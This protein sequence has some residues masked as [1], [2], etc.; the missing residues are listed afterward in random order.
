MSDD[1]DQPVMKGTPIT[2]S[3]G[4]LIRVGWRAEGYSV[5]ASTE[6]AYFIYTMLLLAVAILLGIVVAYSVDVLYFTFIGPQVA[7]VV[8]EIK[9]FPNLIRLMIYYSTLFCGGIIFWHIRAMVGS[10]LVRGSTRLHEG[11]SIVEQRRR[12]SIKRK[13]AYL[14][15]ILLAVAVW[16]FPE[17]EGLLPFPMDASVH[18]FLTS[19]LILPV[20][21][22]IVFKMWKR[23]G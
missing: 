5:N 22:G 4:R 6:K 18:L 12:A 15:F 20:A 17:A 16:F 3:G 9:H 11:Y 2:R 19:I 8:P 10:V 23:Q 21:E 7:K 1:D 13:R 14:F